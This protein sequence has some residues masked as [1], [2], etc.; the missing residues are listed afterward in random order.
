MK[1]ED[2]TEVGAYEAKTRLPELLRQ[3]K[4]G[5][6]YTIPNRGEAVADLVPCEAGRVRNHKAVIEKFQAYLAGNPV[7]GRVNLRQ[8]IEEGRE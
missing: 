7:R 3:V 1:I 8:L 4:A 5:R 2:K 6:R